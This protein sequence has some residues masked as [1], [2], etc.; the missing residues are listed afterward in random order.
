MQDAWEWQV[1]VGDRLH[2]RPRQ[3][4]PLAAAPED[5]VPAFDHVMPEC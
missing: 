3:S 4:V 1:S 2:P 5:D